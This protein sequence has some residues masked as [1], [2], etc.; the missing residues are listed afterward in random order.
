MN[1]SSTDERSMLET[2]VYE[3]LAIARDDLTPALPAKIAIEINNSCNHKCFFCPNPTMDRTRSVMEEKLLYRIM[4]DARSNGIKELSF[5]STGE[6]FLNRKLPD[7]VR[8]AKEIGF[9]YVFLSS[10]G[11]KAVSKRILP[12]LEAGLD[13]LKFSINAGDRETYAKVHGHDEF[14]DV[15][16]N[17]ELVSEY[18]KR[19]GSPKS[20]FVSFVVTEM[21]EPTFDRL[22]ERIGDLVDEIGRYPFMVLGTPLRR[23]VESDGTERPFVGYE[24]VKPNEDVEARLELPCFQLW[25]YL[26]VTLEGYLTACCSDFN[27]DLVVGNLQKNSL[28]DAWHSPEFRELRAQ[29]IRKEVAGTMCESCIMQRNIPYETINPHLH[30]G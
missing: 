16:R 4:E 17:L 10:N 24:D 25:S 3:R 1:D 12:V 8:Y 13:S 20:L 29:H 28:I 22:Q 23:R 6:P 9:D 11:G 15:V 14:E 18:R 26:N 21:S 30:T 2:Q 27:N 5:Y 19:T 7:Y